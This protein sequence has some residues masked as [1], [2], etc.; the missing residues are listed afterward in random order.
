MYFRHCHLEQKEYAFIM[1][2]AFIL[3]FISYGVFDSQNNCYISARI[4]TFFCY[5]ISGTR[6]YNK[7]V[8]DYSL[9]DIFCL[10]LSCFTSFQVRNISI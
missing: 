3:A 5:T 10:N 9:C 2:I 1:I 8:F 4:L 7:M 6:K